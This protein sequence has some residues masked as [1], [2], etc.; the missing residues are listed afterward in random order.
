MSE[1]PVE[2]TP[3][4]LQKIVAPV[5]KHRTKILVVTNVATLATAVVFKSGLSQ[6]NDFLKEHGLFE[7]FYNKAPEA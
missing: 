6:H 1:T 5:Y 3:T 7:Q 4:T 2:N